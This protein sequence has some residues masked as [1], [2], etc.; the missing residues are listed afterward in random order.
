M[1]RPY[2]LIAC[3]CEKCILA[4]TQAVRIAGT[5]THP[6]TELHG[7]RATGYLAAQRRNMESVG[8]YILDSLGDL[9]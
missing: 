4:N 9:S 2:V 7:T 8:S 3:E 6:G 5:K 1:S